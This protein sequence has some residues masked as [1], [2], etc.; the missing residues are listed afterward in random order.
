MERCFRWIPRWAR[1]DLHAI[2]SRSAMNDPQTAIAVLE[3]D[4]ALLLPRARELAH[5]L[6]LPLIRPDAFTDYTLALRHTDLGLE[7]FETAAPK[8]PGLRIDLTAIDLRTG[9]GN[10][11][12]HQPLARAVGPKPR[13]VLD[14]TAGLCHDAALLACMGYDVTAIERS[15]IV[16]ALLDDALARALKHPAFEPI[17]R[18]HLKLLA[19]DAKRH[20]ADGDDPPDVVYLD[21]MYPPKK[22][23]SALA[24]K[25]VRMLRTLV[26]DDPDADDLLPIALNCARQRVVVKRH[27]HAP[28]L[29]DAAPTHA[30]TSKLVRYDV[31][32]INRA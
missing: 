16:H 17:C 30:I 9:A 4:D 24:R 5:R 2:M 31:Y 11:S 10:L 22:R 7:L 14:A 23:A 6:K 20:M 18:A 21:P 15:P 19:G 3:P 1:V 12:K 28:H 8:H 26:G 13:A 32:M 25:P 27:A 29:A